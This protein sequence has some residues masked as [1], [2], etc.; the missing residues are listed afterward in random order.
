MARHCTECWRTGHNKRTCPK[1]TERYLRYSKQE[2]ESNKDEPKVDGIFP[3]YW[4]MQYVKRTGLHPDGSKAPKGAKRKQ[5]RQCTWCKSQFGQYNEEEG[6]D[7][8]RRTCQ[9]RKDWHAEFKAE[10]A[11]YRRDLLER[12]KESGF[13]IGTLV[14]RKE[15]DYYPNTSGGKDWE[16]QERL[17]M[18]AGI[19]WTNL[20][21]NTNRREIVT[22]RDVGMP[23]RTP[24]GDRMPLV[25]ECDA[26]HAF[27]GRAYYQ[28]GYETLSP[29]G[30]LATMPEGWLDGE[31]L[32]VSEPH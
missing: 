8:N 19:D 18:V 21:Q 15:Y 25:V 5:R 26:E 10:A 1:L 32:S 31:V 23:S 2:Q 22:F 27:H 24:N 28:E 3:G 17:L 7:H 13:G 11:K 9:Y 6:W 29:S 12:M 20:H 4:T 16:Q 14:R 30:S